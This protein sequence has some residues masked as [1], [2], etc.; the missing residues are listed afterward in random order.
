MNMKIVDTF[1]FW[2]EFD[3]LEL[4]LSETYDYIDEFVIVE[5]DYTFTGKYKGYGLETHKD[6]YAKWWDKVTYIKVSDP[7]NTGNPWDNERWQRGNFS[8]GWKDLGKDDVIIVSDVDEIVR[9]RCLVEIRNT[10]YD[11]YVFRMAAFTLRYNY[12]CL[13]Y[14]WVKAKAFR[15]YQ[16]HGEDMRN[17]KNFNDKKVLNME[18]S[19]WHFT[20]LGNESEITNKIQS[21]S[22]FEMNTPKFLNSLNIEKSIQ[23]NRNHFNTRMAK[24]TIDSYFPKSLIE[25]L[26]KYSNLILTDTDKTVQDYFPGSYT[27]TNRINLNEHPTISQENSD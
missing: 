17:M 19:G 13:D 14:P 7:P 8:L 10:D 15:G 12:L 18:H 25:N 9:P 23:E 27:Y 3:I 4:R 22:H 26:E 21:F 5:C 16:A 6:R 11:V 1:L 24:V 20:W 2:N